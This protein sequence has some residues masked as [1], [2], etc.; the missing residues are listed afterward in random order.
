MLQDV[1]KQREKMSM[2]QTICQRR[3]VLDQQQFNNN[4]DKCPVTHYPGDKQSR[5]IR[6]FE[7][8]LAALTKTPN[9]TVRSEFRRFHAA[10]I[11]RR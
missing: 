11:E 5:T 4:S 7:I 1:I 6:T 9:M 3:L 2:Q 10:D 8:L